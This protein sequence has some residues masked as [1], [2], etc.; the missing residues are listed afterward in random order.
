MDNDSSLIADAVRAAMSIVEKSDLSD[1][2]ASV[3][4][5]VMEAPE[6]TLEDQIT[7]LAMF[8]YARHLPSSCG[9]MLDP[10][11]TLIAIVEG[12]GEFT[13]SVKAKDLL[14]LLVMMD[15][16]IVY[17]KGRQSNVEA[18]SCLGKRSRTF[19]KR[20]AIIKVMYTDME[21]RSRKLKAHGRLAMLIQ[22]EMDH[23]NQSQNDKTLR[24]EGLGGA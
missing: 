8:M 7:A 5:Q 15:P 2:N 17:R 21:G 10:P 16:K 4:K 23:L 6:A 24:E 3:A 18:C 22:H 20:S 13:L 9:N 11:R 12:N 14:N 1:L 19:I